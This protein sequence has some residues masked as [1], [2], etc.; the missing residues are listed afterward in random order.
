MPLRVRSL[1]LTCMAIL[2]GSA[3]ALTAAPLAAQGAAPFA[4]A[5]AESDPFAMFVPNDTPVQHTIDYDIWDYALKQMVVWMGPSLR[6]RPALT[7]AN[8]AQG[9][10][11]VGHNSRF[12]T[13][14]AMVAFSRFGQDAIASFTEYRQELERVAETLE[15]RTLPRNEQL[16]FWLNLHNVAMVEQ[17]AI[18]WPVRQPRLLEI[19][20][21]PLSDAKIINIRGVDMSLRDIRER[22]VYANWQDPKVIY[23]FWL[24]EIGSPSLERAA[25][26]GGNVASL[27]EIKAAEYINSLRANEK[28]GDTLH[29]ST[30]Y[31]DVGR[32]YFPSFGPD[33]RA[34]MMQFGNEDVARMIAKTTKTKASIREWDIADLSGGRRDSIAVQGARPGISAGMMEVLAQR[35]RKFRK[36]KKKEMPTGRVYFTELILPGDDPNKGKVE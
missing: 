34:H 20:G 32:F 12:R 18:H 6:E 9:R 4:S 29:V 24:G 5:Q 13:E 19:G 23:G 15:I 2:A 17:I 14:G 36:L 27:L 16:A 26:T 33:V 8:A 31:E 1:A 30:L 28:R 3:A 11:R 7:R 10:I 22:I 35:E 21:A 25:F